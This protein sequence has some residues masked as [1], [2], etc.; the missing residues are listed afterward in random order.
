V[1]AADATF[2]LDRRDGG[3]PEPRWCSH[4]GEGVVA[5]ATGDHAVAL[6]TGATGDA[7]PTRLV[8]F[9]A[10]FGEATWGYAAAAEPVATALLD[11]GV[12]VT[13]RRGTVAALG[14]A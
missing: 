10:R 2:A 8:A 3:A 14:G 11:G 12:V 6:H 5:A 1:E 13:T 7:A 4:A 9:T